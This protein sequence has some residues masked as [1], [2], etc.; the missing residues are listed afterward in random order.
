MFIGT[1][2]GNAIIKGT[3]QDQAPVDVYGNPIDVPQENLFLYAGLMVL[4]TFIPLFFA[5]R[6]Y[7]K[8][9]GAKRGAEGK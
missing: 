1:L 7:D 2:V 9:I 8:R 4:L 6:E 5:W 3:P